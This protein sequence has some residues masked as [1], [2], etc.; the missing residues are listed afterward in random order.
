MTA[1]RLIIAVPSKGRLEERTHRFFEASGLPIKRGE[2]ARLYSG[3]LPSV[4][5][6][7][8]L[9]VAA[10]EI[11][12]LLDNGV[13]HLGVTGEDLLHERLV[14]IDRSVLVLKRLG[15][16]FAD[17][18]VAV[19]RSWIDVRSMADLDDVAVEFH[20]RRG[21]RLRVATKY[22][23]LTRAFFAEHGIADYRIVESMG[24]TEGA[25]ASGA[26][27]A[28]VDITSTGATLSANNLKVLED[29]LILK[30]EATLSASLRAPWGA[31]TRH[32]LRHVLDMI[33]AHDRAEA[34][35]VIRVARDGRDLRQLAAELAGEHG[36]VPLSD[37]LAA[38][39]NGGDLALQCPSASL[40]A[41][42]ERLRGVGCT[43]VVVDQA[44]Y[45]FEAENPYYA[46]LAGRLGWTENGA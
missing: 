4:P 23:S 3:R 1:E 9:Y 44:D 42:V 31:G 6:A 45:I 37:D 32:A 39:T 30:S 28:I 36:C 46:A 22:L 38:P 15:F 2:S 10:G 34:M 41:V 33:A 24:A 21:R 19:P 8:I 40:Y 11:P 13:A 5:D 26:A 43:R 17:L 27:E 18:V 29:G 7:E 14:A 25:P 20:R 35:R 16:G 12:D